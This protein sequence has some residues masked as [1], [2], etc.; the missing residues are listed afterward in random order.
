MKTVKLKG[1]EGDFHIQAEHGVFVTLL[2]MQW[3]SVNGELFYMPTKIGFKEWQ[4][5]GGSLSR[6]A[7]VKYS[8][9]NLSCHKNQVEG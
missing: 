2:A 5:M 8:Y 4:A 6:E 9:G 1:I 7:K 3:Q